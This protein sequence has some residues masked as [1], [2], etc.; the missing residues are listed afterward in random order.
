[1]KH[2]LT[3]SSHSP[4]PHSC[5]PVHRFAGA[6]PTANHSLC[7]SSTYSAGK[8]GFMPPSVQ[9]SGL[10]QLCQFLHLVAILYLTIP[11]FLQDHVPQIRILSAGQ[12]G[13]R[14]Q[15]CCSALFHFCC[16]TRHRARLSSWEIF[17]MTMITSKML[18]L[19]GPQG[20]PCFQRAGALRVSLA[21]FDVMNIT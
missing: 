1:M 21:M 4:F 19:I 18:T 10:T 16:P 20:N 9:A 17:R 13:G 15:A 7:V 8:E 12:R 2:V 3:P 5:A 14:S 11:S 6:A